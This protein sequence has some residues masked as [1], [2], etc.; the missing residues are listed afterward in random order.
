MDC[1]ELGVSGLRVSRFC[2][3]CM[4]LGHKLTGDRLDALADRYREAGGNFFD[5]AHCYSFWTPAG[6]GASERALGDYVKRRRC[7]D[8]VVIA[9]KGAHPPVEGYR[10][11][12]DY[13][14][15]RRVRADIDESLARLGVDRIDLYWLHRDDPR[16]EVGGIVQMLDEEVRRGRIRAFG[17][18]NWTS[19]RLDAANDYARQHGLA[20]F[21]ASQPRWSLLHPPAVSEA[22]RLVPGVIVTVND[23]DRRWHA[24]TQLAVVPFG[25]T[26]NGFFAMSGA[27]PEKWR[28]PENLARSRRASDLA[29]RLGATP[30]QVALAW[31]V[32][33]PFPVI[34]ILGTTDE[35]HLADALG[36]DR[37]S[38]TD[39]QC[40]W[41]EQGD[42]A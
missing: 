34:P 35:S 15:P 7:R 17:G 10:D 9:T 23:A 39:A 5:T 40:R 18:S 32:C 12:S 14:S 38:L 16:I 33:Q 24:Q 28:S 31:L 26:G 37:V 22:E 36:S 27:Q 21:V 20:G 1:I 4:P 2:L 11:D 3:G 30:N 13:L 6:A 29:A 8:S 42:S 25:P 19:A 41:L